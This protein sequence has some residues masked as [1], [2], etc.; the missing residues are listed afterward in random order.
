M[1]AYIACGV[2]GVGGHAGLAH[3]AQE[4]GN[5]GR[6]AGP[7]GFDAGD[8]QTVHGA[9]EIIAVEDGG[10]VCLAGE[11]PVGGGVNEYGTA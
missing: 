7:V 3:A 9:L 2:D 11:A 1:L 4:C 8:I 5:F 6:F 10:F